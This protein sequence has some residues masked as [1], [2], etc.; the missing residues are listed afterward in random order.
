M[1]YLDGTMWLDI[2][3]T[4]ATNE[5]RFAELGVINIVKDS[6]NFVDY[7]SPSY[8]AKLAE[9]SDLRK[10]QIPVMINQTPT[11]VATP[12]FNFIPANLEQ[13]AEYY[14][15]C[16]DVFSGMRHY[17]ASY[18]N[19]TIDSDWARQ[20]K[21]KNIAYQM[22]IFIEG[23]LLTNLEARKTQVLDY[24]TQVS[25]GDGTFTFNAGTDTLEVNKAAQKETMFYNLEKL[26]DANELPGRYALVTSRAGMAVQKS[27]ALK[28]GNNNT[29]D[30]QALGF[31]PLDRIHESGNITPGSNVFNG[32]LVRDGAIGVFENYPYDFRAG[33]MFAGK[34]WS[35]SDTE[36]PWCRLRANI[37]TNIE[38]TEAT[39]LV[40]AGTDSNL[41]MTHFEEMA[42]WIRFYV[43]YRYNSN[44]ATRAQDIVKI[45]GF[46][47]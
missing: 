16:Y 22:G 42:I 2:Q 39:A 9:I 8:R 21:M 10:L 47:S 35:V 45:S 28:Y 38:A 29:K 41:I 25:Q 30:L 33:T 18:G 46:T 32:F 3:S 23:I 37:Y 15:V 5:K 13:T 1:A 11:V 14:F 44:L 4:D 27:E 12:G 43:V 26:M 6:T 40:S 31:M 17:P 19:N 36:I 7:I 24:T 20:E 34:K